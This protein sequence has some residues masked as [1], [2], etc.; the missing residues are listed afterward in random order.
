MK[1][2]IGTKNQGKIEAVKQ[3][4]LIYPNFSKAIIESFNVDSGVKNQPMGLD[5]TITGAKNRAK[6]AFELNTGD[7]GFGLESGIFE[8]PHTKSDYMDT[9][10]CAIFDGKNFHIGL[11]SCFEYPKS[12]IQKILNEGK[13]ISDIAVELGFAEDRNFRENQG[14]VG[15]LTKGVITRMEYSKQAV[16]VALIHLLNKEHY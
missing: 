16:I 7:F 10:A 9:T 15:V 14:M 4:L 11:S 2:S 6:A 5:E 13:E 12:L 3:A 1:I 8:V